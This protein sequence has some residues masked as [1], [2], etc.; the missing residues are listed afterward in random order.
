MMD[1]TGSG[2]LPLV[3]SVSDTCQTA[4]V[5]VPLQLYPDNCQ[6]GQGIGEILPDSISF[7]PPVNL[8]RDLM[9]CSNLT[10]SLSDRLV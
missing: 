1:I 8:L 3:V 9:E 2:V 5:T 4:S 10:H 6:S 7:V